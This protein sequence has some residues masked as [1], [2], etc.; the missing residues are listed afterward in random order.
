LLKEIPNGLPINRSASSYWQTNLF[1]TTS[2]N[3]ATPLLK[4][5]IDNIGLSRIMYSIDYPYVNMQEGQDWIDRQLP[6]SLVASDLLELKGGT[7]IKVLGLD[8]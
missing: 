1:E 7:A 8:K 2:G 6:S 3:F 4:F 5:H